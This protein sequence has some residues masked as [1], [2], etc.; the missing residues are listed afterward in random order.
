[1]QVAGYFYYFGH[2]YAGLGLAELPDDEKAPY[3]AMLARLMLDRQEKSGAWFDYP[4]YDYH[5]PYGTS[6]ALMA[7]YRCLP[8]D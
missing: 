7:L 4:L 8:V 2:Y 6:Y 3:Q 5:D 1:M